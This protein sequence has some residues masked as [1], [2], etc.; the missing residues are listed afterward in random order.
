MTESPDQHK[1]QEFT[2]NYI[3]PDS[4]K[5][6]Q[7]FIEP[8]LANL[9]LEPMFQFQR[10]GYFIVDTE[11]SDQNL[12]FNKTWVLGTLGRSN[13]NSLNSWAFSFIKAE[14]YSFFFRSFC[15]FI[16]SPIW[17][18]AVKEATMLFKHVTSCLRRVG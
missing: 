12:I 3:N 1:E 15:S 9:I 17:L 6:V 5:T 11:S 4:L 2:S 13:S 18:L 14:N 16:A 10:L 7:G 8:N